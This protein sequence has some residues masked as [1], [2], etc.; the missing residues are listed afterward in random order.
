MNI[1]LIY[2]IFDSSVLSS[3]I[4]FVDIVPVDISQT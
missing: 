4:D 1:I 3:H 2:T